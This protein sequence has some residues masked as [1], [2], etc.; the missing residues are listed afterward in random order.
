[1]NKIHFIAIGGSIMH[2][3]AIALRKK[4]LRVSGSDDEIFEPARS[5]LAK[6]K[7]LPIKKGW[8]PALISKGLDAVILG[9]HARADNPELQKARE[10]GIPIY[11]FPEYV[12]EASRNK[13]RVAIA[14][15]HGKTTITGMVMHLLQ[16]AG[17]DFD[18]L[19]G[20]NLKG[21][22][23][24][25]KLT[26]T[27]PSI[28]LEADEYLA[29]ALNPVPK[30]LFYK[31]QIAIITGIAWDHV[32]AF[33]T[34]ENYLGQFRKFI[35]SMQEGGQ[36][37]YNL[38][39]KELTAMVEKEAGHLKTTPY[40]TPAYQMV[41]GEWQM[42]FAGQNLPLKIF[43]RHNMQ[44]MMGAI[45]VCQALGL[46]E[47]DIINGGPGFEGAAKR[48][49]KL[50]S[51]E[52]AAVFRDYAHSPSKVK[53]TVNAARERY[54]GRK[55]VACLELH[56]FSSLNTDFLPHYEGTMDS[57]DVKAIF[58]DPHAVKLKKMKLA[59]AD[60][61][62][63][64]AGKGLKIFE[65]RESLLGF[66]KKQDWENANLL[67]MSSGNFANINLSELAT[68]VVS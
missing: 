34:Y 38:E 22:D 54:P 42:E 32:N 58:F 27:A 40:K 5:R 53:A 37:I 51:S 23:L 65:D 45:T 50:A 25:V 21:F 44:N 41:A 39:D 18:Y 31:P 10:L 11:S 8:D 19:V 63:V 12:F 52:T 2:N 64:F 62:S 13:T 24:M 28:I 20:A 49:E 9:M 43:G 1:M 55:L 33:P 16:S 26:A 48:L 61:E 68:F 36:L 67:L 29:S 30:F 60:I 15:S 7:L 14:G 4:G 3:L 35:H 66:L 57:A 59:R 17:K 56:T 6:Y 47:N 46:K